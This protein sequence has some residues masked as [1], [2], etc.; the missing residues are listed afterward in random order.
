MINLMPDPLKKEIRAA[1]ANVVL[2]RYINTM[3]I[4]SLFLAFI[5]WGSFMLLGQIQDS[6]KKQIE[7]SDT[8]AAVYSQTKEQVTSLSTGLSEAKT[9]LDQ[10]ILYSNVLVNIAQQMPVNT[11]IEKLTLDSTSFNGTPMTLKVYAKTSDDAVAIRERFQSSPFFSNV[12]FESISDTSGGIDGYPVSV[13]MTL[14]L[15]RTIAQ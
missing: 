12:N 8:R 15:N 10:E 11:V 4:S 14:T 9:I 2:V 6:A 13:T 1:R 3:V 7:A 5:L